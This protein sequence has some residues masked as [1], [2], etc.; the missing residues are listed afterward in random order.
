MPW[1][2]QFR[3]KEANDLLIIL[4]ANPS[5]ALQPIFHKRIG[6]DTFV[7][8]M[9]RLREDARFKAV[10][11][12]VLVVDVTLEDSYTSV[13]GQAEDA[14]DGEGEIWMDWG[15]V[16]FWKEHYCKRLRSPQWRSRCVKL[17]WIPSRHDSEVNNKRS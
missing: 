2:A 11:H 17:I 7:S 9:S 8:R 5:E 16:E 12:D 14:T 13:P 6:A 4:T 1:I 3:T 15:F 10:R